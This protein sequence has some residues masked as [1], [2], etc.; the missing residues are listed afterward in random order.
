MA[1]LKEELYAQLRRFDDEAFAALANRGLLRRAQKDVEKEMPALLS[2][3]P[4]ALTVGAGGFEISF[5]KRGPAHARCT[6]PATSV[7]QHILAAALALQK[8]AQ[9]A[10]GAAPVAPAASTATASTDTPA[11]VAAKVDAAPEPAAGAPAPATP[12]AAP[13]DDDV[14]NLHAALLHITPAELRSHA[15]KA[16][17]AWAWQYV[18]DLAP[19][20]DVEVRADKNILISLRHPRIAFRYMGGGIARLI[21]DLEIRQIE[22]Y[23]VAAVLAY[24]KAN[25]V[26]HAPPEAKTARPAAQALDLGRD[27]E[28]AVGSDQQDSRARLRQAVRQLSGECLQLGLSHLSPAIQERFS[29]L[30]VWAQG[31]EY[32]RLA[33]L[34]RRLADH[35]ELLL[36]RAGAADEYRLLDELSL[37]RA[38][39]EALAAHAGG[40]APAHLVGQSRSTYDEIATLELTALGALPWRSASGYLGLTMLFWS[41]KDRQFHSCTDARPELQ[42]FDPIA[43]YRAPG[44]W[45]GIGSPALMTGRGVRLLKPQ[46]NRAGRLSLSAQTTATLLDVTDW[47]Q[48]LPPVVER[49]SELAERYAHAR[50]SLLAE[51]RPLQDWFVLKPARFGARDFDGVRQRLDWQLE[52]ADGASLRASLTFSPYTEHA[53]GRIEQFSAGDLPP[54]TL[55]VGRLAGTA[56]ELVLEPLSLIHPAQGRIDALHFDAGPKQAALSRWFGKLKGAGAPATT[57]VFAGQQALVPS[58]MRELRHW[59]REQAER[60]MPD[61]GAPQ[62][63]SSGTQ[64]RKQM[65]QQVGRCLQVG[66][67]AFSLPVPAG[68]ETEPAPD[69]LLRANY[70]CMQY[71]RLIVGSEEEE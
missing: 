3:T 58:Q 38:L 64:W 52:D 20:E 67:T 35:V 63:S 15:G 62:Q 39:V 50:R 12:L 41:P 18:Q 55:V 60:G 1:T 24:Q 16:G 5:D 14:S 59:L 42:R 30:A 36:E 7:C 25:G 2:E 21:A 47:P 68:G 44:P 71:E 37:A 9:Q 48:A 10:S 65:D 46:V 23:R 69:A 4:A 8:L 17:Y 26:S 57:P 28:V 43:R 11:A 51:A 66:L 22:K 54:G 40:H 6:C 61:A 33:L 32:Y 27:H 45:S 13:V 19:E 56:G 31:A 34:L 49:W 53:I 29:T 70:L